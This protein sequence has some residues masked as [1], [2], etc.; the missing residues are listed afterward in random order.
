MKSVEEG[1]SEL[2]VACRDGAVDLEMADQALDAVSLAIND[3]VP[4][5]RG[6]AMGARR[7]GSADAPIAQSAAD[8]VGVVAFVGEQIG[9]AGFG[10]RRHGFERRAVRRFAA[11][12]MEDEGDAAGITETVNLTGEPAPRAAKSLFAS[13]PFAPA[14]E[15]WPRT[16]VES[17]LWREL[18][19]IAC[20]S[21]EAVASQTPASL[22]RRKRWYTVIH[23][24]YFSGTSRHGAPVRKR[25]KIPFTTVRLS[26]AGRLLRPRSGG[27]K[28]FSRRHSASLRSPRLRDPS[29]PRGILESGRES[30]VNHFVNRT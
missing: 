26:C 25:H 6:L 24:P 1:S 5:D 2:V 17:M 9:G 15:T 23:L 30:G 27:S 16:V 18:S 7:N 28:S 20:A 22:Q 8:G 4:S 19:A 11:G 12:E 10:E 14:A 3:A 29:S 21:A 13:P